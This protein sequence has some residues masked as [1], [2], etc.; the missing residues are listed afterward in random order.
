MT[1]ISTFST[2]KFKVENV[3]SEI[4]HCAAAVVFEIKHL[5]IFT[6]PKFE[7]PHHKCCVRSVLLHCHP[8]LNIQD[9]W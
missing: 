8:S 1:I 6:N 9:T 3:S 5:E 4:F 7:I 2:E